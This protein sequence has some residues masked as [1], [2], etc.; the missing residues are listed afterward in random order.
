MSGK[1][2]MAAGEPPKTMESHFAN[3]GV[4]NIAGLTEKYFSQPTR[5]LVLI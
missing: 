2:L 5:V 3:I 4:E 1:G